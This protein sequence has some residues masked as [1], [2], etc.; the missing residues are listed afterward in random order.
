MFQA[1]NFLRRLREDDISV[2]ESK[3]EVLSRAGILDNMPRNVPLD[4]EE[5][6]EQWK[7]AVCHFE[8]YQ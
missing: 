6:T 4:R 3:L 8:W 2:T 1:S 5:I 7:D